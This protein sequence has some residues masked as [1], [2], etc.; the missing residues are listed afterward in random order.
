MNIL[1]K[2]ILIA[3]LIFYYLP[4]STL[5]QAPDTL[6]TKTFGG[7]LSDWGLSAE[8]TTDGGFIITGQFQ[9]GADY[10]IGL[11]KTDGEGSLEWL[12]SFSGNTPKGSSVKQTSDGG[13]I[14]AG[15][16][17]SSGTSNDVY[18]I[19]TDLSGNYQ[20]AKT[21]GGTDNDFG[22]SVKQTQDGGYI[23]AGSTS[24]FGAGSNDVWLIKVDSNGNQDWA[25]T[26]GGTGNDGGYGVEIAADGGYVAAGGHNSF[27]SGDY[28]V[29]LLKT[30]A[31]GNLLWLKSFGGTLADFG[32]SVKKTTDGG[33][34]I[35]GYTESFSLGGKDVWL[36]KTDS[37][38]ELE[39]SKNYGGFQDDEGKSVDQ[40]ADGGYI[41]TGITESFGVGSI[42]VG[43]L[44]T[45]SVG[46]LLWITT[47][48]GAN[49]EFWTSSSTDY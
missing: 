20:W 11:L 5:A 13:Y 43:V 27:G 18:L 14:I 9:S 25:K 32:Y 41:L 10:Y 48:G 38:G 46:N 15:N 17:F 28:D 36:V 6:W 19:K 22:R 29:G 30:D 31:N 45:D 26:F 49:S 21:Y 35:I 4:H 12:K 7:V 33:F 40:T 16:N 24:S 37:D 47:I 34:V 2:V 8:Q 3:A 39:W 42:E 23:I 44:K 1:S